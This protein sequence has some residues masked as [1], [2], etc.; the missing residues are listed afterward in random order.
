VVLYFMAR[1]LADDAKA[2]RVAALAMMVE[3]Y[4]VA[5]LTRDEAEP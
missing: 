2:A 1:Q 4:R 3:A 5:G